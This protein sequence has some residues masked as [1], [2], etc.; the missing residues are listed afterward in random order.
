MTTKF[1]ENCGAA[2]AP[3]GRFCEGCGHPVEPTAGVP[4]PRAVPSPTIPAPSAAPA[5]T[6]TYVAPIAPTAYP[7]PAN[8]GT[9]GLPLILLGVVVL[10]AAG[11]GGWWWM[12][13]P[14]APTTGTAPPTTTTPGSPPATPIAGPGDAFVGAWYPEDE[15]G[16]GDRN[17]RLVIT[18]LGNKLIG[19]SDQSSEGRMELAI[20]PGDKLEGT[21]T[22]PN[23]DVIPVTV[24]MLAG[25]KKMVLTLA[26]PASEYQT[27]VLWKDE[28]EQ[29]GMT[30]SS[31][32]RS[33]DED[34]A[35]QK[36]AALPEVKGFIKTL[37][38]QGKRARFDAS[39]EDGASYSVRVYEIVDDGGG[40]SHS[41]TF[42]WYKVD[43]NSGAVTPGM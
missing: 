26:P 36:V 11:G 40:A 2:L 30:Q 20:V 4:A 28:S 23:G 17:E 9:K 12:N 3:D 34:G 13:R 7:A 8:G 24:E 37:E 15:S 19:L 32:S 27:V 35:L 10:A 1:C 31:V 14:K 21:F 5:P 41:A 38:A 29:A 33:L 43:R 42:G 39:L 18:K 16:N 25:G 6:P 22:D